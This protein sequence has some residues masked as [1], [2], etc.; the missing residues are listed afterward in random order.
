MPFLSI[1]SGR[2]FYKAT[3]AS[4]P[5]SSKATLILHHGLGSTH[6]YHQA[7]VPALTA[8]PYNFRCITYDA[9]S[10]GLSD[11]AKG[12]QSIETVSQDVIDVLDALKIEKAVF[13][14]HS[15]A[16]IVAAHL[17]ATTKDR[18]LAAVMLGPVLPSEDVAKLFEARVKTIEESERQPEMSARQ[19][20]CLG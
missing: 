1:P 14:G 2:I 6:T 13:V 7:I 20:I 9:I 12:P 4:S 8:A 11:L 15:F 16:G 18:I 3:Q 5:N 17:A 19:D 10:C